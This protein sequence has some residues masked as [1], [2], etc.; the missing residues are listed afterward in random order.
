[1]SGVHS[2][3][4]VQ[5]AFRVPKVATSVEA[6]PFHSESTRP[7]TRNY[8]RIRLIDT[9]VG[10]TR[11]VRV[12]RPVVFV[13]TVTFTGMRIDLRTIDTSGTMRYLA[14]STSTGD[15]DATRTRTRILELGVSRVWRLPVARVDG[16]SRSQ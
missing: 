13:R 9:R 15:L 3:A 2:E 6:R 11:T 16:T 5:L 8:R 10:R 14:V 1:M 7:G 12:V 4:A